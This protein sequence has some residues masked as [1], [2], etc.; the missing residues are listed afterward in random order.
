M[1]S[2]RA[3]WDDVK[4]TVGNNRLSIIMPI[5]NLASQVLS[6]IRKTAELFAANGINA[7]IIPVDDGSLDGT[8]SLLAKVSTEKFDCVTIKPVI[9]P[10]NGGKGAALRAGF[11]ASTGELV[12]L[13]DGDLDIFV[14]A[15]LKHI[16]SK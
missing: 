1:I 4:K 7:E 12:M 6:N 2:K 9:C 13:L 5:Y 10:V 16:A 8:G 15:Y 3:T 11:D 14:D